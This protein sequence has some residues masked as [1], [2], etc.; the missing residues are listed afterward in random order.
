MDQEVA[1]PPVAPYVAHVAVLEIIDR[2]GSVRDNVAVREWPLRVGRAL[3]NHFVLDDPYTAAHHFIVEP[4][5]EGHVT[6]V[7]GDT[8]NGVQCGLHHVKSGERFSIG[9]SPLAMMIGRTSLRLR[10]ASHVLPPEQALIPVRSF[11]QSWSTIAVLAVV[12]ALT[13]MVGNY[14]EAEPN[15][16]VR[17]L[18]PLGLWAIAVLLGW[19]A[20]WTLL[21]KIFTR[22]GRF[23]WHLSVFLIAVLAW[24][25]ATAGSALMAFSFS[26]PWVTDFAFIP[27]YAIVGA[28][29]YF[30]VQG[31]EPHYPRRI[32]AVSLS[33]VVTA[34]VLNL[35]F[36][37]QLTDRFGA[38]LYMNHLFPPAVRVV[39]PV[40]MANF[41]QGVEAMQPTLDAKAR[42]DVAP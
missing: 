8:L 29:L 27:V 36:N 31:V 35:W 32:R 3:D 13:L 12:T 14:F 38:E 21:S 37:W 9:D 19:T 23:G 11:N 16:F 1:A 28:M 4:D 10:L 41:M 18:G 30:H 22:Q 20:L 5:A 6:L 34:V 26:W 25:V 2:D 24:Q 15:N 17:S 40:D 33:G 39:A 42:K 7:A